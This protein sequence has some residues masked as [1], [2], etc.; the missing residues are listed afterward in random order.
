MK[1]R[2]LLLVVLTVSV[3]LTQAQPTYPAAAYA[4]VG[5]QFLYSTANIGVQLLDFDSTGAGISWDYS[6]LPVA[7][8]SPVSY[9][10]PDDGGYYLG[11]LSACVLSGNWPWVCQGNWDNLTNLAVEGQDSLALGGFQFS[12]AV[13]HLHKNNQTL[14]E[15][16][17]GI[18]LGTGQLSLPLLIEYDNVDTVYRFPFQYQNIDSSYRAFNVDLTQAG[19]GL[20]Y[21]SRQQRINEVAGWGSLITPFDT[22][23][24]VLKMRTD[25]YTTDSTLVN[26]DTISLGT[27]H[28]VIY[29]W[30]DPAFGQAVLEAEG[31]VVAGLELITTVRFLDTLRCLQPNPAFVTSPLL[32]LVDPQSGTVDVTFNNNSSNADSYSWDFGDGGTSTQQ[33]PTHTYS[34]GGIYLVQLVACNSVCSPLWCDTTTFPVVVIDT[35][36]SLNAAFFVTPVF[37]RCAGTEITFNSISSNASSYQ[38]Y[39]GDGDSANVEDPSH[40]YA[41]GGAYSVMLIASNG[42]NADTSIQTVNISDRPDPALGPDISMTNHDSLLLTANGG[43]AFNWSDGSSQ[44]SLLVDGTQYAAGSYDFWVEVTDQQ[45]CVGRDTLTITI[46]WATGLQGSLPIPYTLYPNPGTKEL[47]LTFPPPDQ[48][49]VNLFSATGAL[50]RS[51]ADVSGGSLRWNTENLAPGLYLLE[52]KTAT[53]SWHSKWIKQ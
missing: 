41:Q 35:A 21:L 18:S 7:T 1:Q 24:S 15:T 27:R 32:P 40:I 46:N 39:F 30:F 29:R 3:S 53:G 36:S 9:I 12:N 34:G 25:I 44:P 49:E 31:Q 51:H 10:D 37:N 47:R 4:A 52:V 38:W 19:L 48:Y 45:G 33:T 13:T 17:L 8:Q 50:L 6:M 14:R 22:F 16:M 20:V 26:G 11:F 43:T 28:S 5:D 2:L 23:A 42:S